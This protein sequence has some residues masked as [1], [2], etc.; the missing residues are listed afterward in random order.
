MSIWTWWGLPWVSTHAEYQVVEIGD[1]KE[2]EWITIIS[3]RV[4]AV[5]SPERYRGKL[6]KVGVELPSIVC[7]CGCTVHIR[8]LCR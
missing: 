4:L 6:E 8:Q 5:G 7:N 1:G 3:E 2:A